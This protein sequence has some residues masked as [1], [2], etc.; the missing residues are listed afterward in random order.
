ML[1]PWDEKTGPGEIL[2]SGPFHAGETLGS[3][4]GASQ[5]S[6]LSSQKGFTEVSGSREGIWSSIREQ[7]GFGSH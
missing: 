6:A 1:D 5:F 2:G 3:K 7:P 4:T